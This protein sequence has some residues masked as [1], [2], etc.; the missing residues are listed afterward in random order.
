MAPDFA[1]EYARKHKDG[2]WHVRFADG[3]KVILSS[4]IV[5]AKIDRD[6]WTEEPPPDWVIE[7]KVINLA[8]LLSA[9]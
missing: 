1:T 9:D 4:K 2:D 3:S 7:S 6:K 5:D 8:K